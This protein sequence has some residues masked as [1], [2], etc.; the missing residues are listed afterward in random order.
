MKRI[1]EL[2]VR[3]ALFAALLVAAAYGFRQLLFVHAPMTF[4][5]HV[6]DMSYGWYVPL[7]SI[8][9]L[10]RERRELVSSLGRPSL[11]GLI[12]AIPFLAFGF[13]GVRG[14]Q[15]RFEMLGFAGL[16]WALSWTFYGWR[17]AKR[18]LF[19]AAFLLFCM[20]LA[21]YL[22]V[23]TVHLRLLA[24]STAFALLKG[25]GLD[26]VRRG[27]MLASSS[28]AFAIDIAEPCSG[29]RS[30][31]ALTALTAGYAYFTQPT[32][33]RRAVLFALAVPIAILGNVMRIV[34]IAIIG[35]TCS[36]DFATG[37]Y[38][39]YSGYV[40]FLVAI[41]LMVAAGG[42]IDRISVAIRGGKKPNETYSQRESTTGEPRREDVSWRGYTVVVL[43]LALI[44]PVM[45]YQARSA[46]PIVCEP[47]EIELG[48]L[49][50]FERTV[51]EPSEAELKTLPSDTQFVKRL[52]TAPGGVWFQVTVVIGGVSKSSIHRPELCLP[53][54]GFQMTDPRDASAA[55]TDWRFISLV[56][57]DAPPLG[58]AYT[59][60]N[61]A[62]FRTPSHMK[63]IFRDVWD[64]SVHNRIDRWVMVTINAFTADDSLLVAFLERIAES[65]SF[66]K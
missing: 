47:P 18:V 42:A 33:L 24:S 62:G 52:Y 4:S 21:T 1:C 16:L 29:L 31:F 55:G 38:H 19:P 20:P 2:H 46:K 17:T 54:Q 32:W 26:V 13:L 44:V 25:F 65:C 8:Y 22:D 10:W 60:F 39:D 50:G 36:E 15:V 41:A 23:V 40:V 56:R 61:Q 48:E 66:L 59:F 30:L 64:R 53:S 49:D 63:R 14:I 57:S 6:E 12:A 45:A 9:V 3:T 37:F 27:T 28:G 58:F 51:L 5:D 34:T 7:F 11:F 35:L 43:S